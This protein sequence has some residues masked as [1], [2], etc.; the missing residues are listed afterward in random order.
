M[1]E[2]WNSNWLRKVNKIYELRATII[3]KHNLDPFKSK[4]IN[5]DSTSSNNG[6]PTKAKKRRIR[7]RMKKWNRVNK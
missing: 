3:T 5:P 6:Q 1:T 2:Y 4:N 7:N